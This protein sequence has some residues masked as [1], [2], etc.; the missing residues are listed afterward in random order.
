MDNLIQA[1]WP[2]WKTVR[3]IGR[4]SFGAVYEIQRDVFGEIEKAALKVISIP[5][6]SADID[7]LRVE[8]Y[9]DESITSRFHGYLEDIVREYSMMAKMKGHPN[10]VYCDDVKYIQHDDGIG[11]DI[12]I[13]MELLTPI[14]KC[15][16]QV[17]NEQ[18][19]IDLGIA[20]CNALVL[21]KER[22]IVHRDIKPQ[23]IFVSRDG[24]FKLGDFG[25]AKT[26]ERTTSGTKV[27]TYKY[28]APEVYN[29]KPYG[30]A[31]DQYSLGL[32]MYW[33]LN[34]R[35]S[36]FSPKKATASEEDAARKRRFDGEQIPPPAHGSKQL[37]AIVLKACAYDPK[38]RFASAAEMLDALNALKNGSAFPAAA[39]PMGAAAA[40]DGGAAAGVAAD[41]MTTGTVGTVGRRRPNTEEEATIGAFGTGAAFVSRQQGQ[42]TDYQNIGQQ[43]GVPD[44]VQ[45]VQ[46]GNDQ[47]T[48]AAAIPSQNKTEEKKKR[49]IGAWIAIAAGLIVVIGGVLFLV[50]RKGNG[51]G[52][53][54]NTVAE[55]NSNSFEQITTEDLIETV[56]K[57]TS[58]AERSAESLAQVNT[59]E[60]ISDESITQVN[61]FYEGEE[62]VW[63]SVTASYNDNCL[64]VDVDF[65]V[66][67][68]MDLVGQWNGRLYIGSKS[69]VNQVT[70]TEAYTI[71]LQG[72]ENAGSYQIK[73]VKTDKATGSVI[74]NA[75]FVITVSNEGNVV[76]SSL[77]YDKSVW[78]RYSVWAEM[79]SGKVYLH[80]NNFGWY[81]EFDFDTYPECTID[82]YTCNNQ[83]L[84]VY[85]ESEDSYSYYTSPSNTMGSAI[86]LQIKEYA[87]GSDSPFSVLSVEV[88]SE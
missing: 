76:L 85:N 21:C 31:A 3:L 27:G 15:L 71:E 20:M 50:L 54:G 73:Q 41:E 45:P 62:S 25:I 40:V 58:E 32:V 37:Q 66:G 53:R 10:V 6:N 51:S 47:Y 82:T 14:M 19:V 74:G 17:E 29:N 86:V 8:G 77:S 83:V 16:D 24:T 67:V 88:V 68:A 30:P 55:I 61:T 28:M 12:Y 72:I 11:W 48:G 5:E 4:G 42:A 59:S 43:N 80:I 63:K 46:Q 22:S 49:G 78:A 33:L 36:P 56:E 52:N 57:Q 13:K 35:R 64:M 39:V 75:S 69:C 26:A 1:P 60:Q 70:E 44:R 23:N 2:G 38:D 65:D 87:S 84:M 34:D 79:V 18:S 7:D 81:G 9:D